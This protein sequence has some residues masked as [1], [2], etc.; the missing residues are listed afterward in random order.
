MP[1]D[2][3]TELKNIETC[4]LLDDFAIYVQFILAAIAFSSLVVK[5]LKEKPRRPFQQ[6]CYDASKQG[7]SAIVVHIFNVLIAEYLQSENYSCVWYFLNIFLDV[8]LGLLITYM[9]IHLCKIIGPHLGI[10]SCYKTGE[11]GNPPSFNKWKNQL[12]VWLCICIFVKFLL[13]L[14]AYWQSNVFL[15]IGVILLYPIHGWPRFELLFVMLV[16]PLIINALYFWVADNFLMSKK[17]IEI[18]PNLK[19][20]P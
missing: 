8:T 19:N 17:Y 15:T 9:L 20:A 5:Y 16:W 2:D 18:V 12:W 10:E 4:K 13:T 7:I 11:Y 1:V 6:W 14:I 3:N